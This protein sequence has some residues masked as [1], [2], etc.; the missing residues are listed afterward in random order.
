MSVLFCMPLIGTDWPVWT[1]KDRDWEEADCH[2]GGLGV[3]F[4]F[5]RFSCLM[6]STSSE[7]SSD[8]LWR[9]RREAPTIGSGYDSP[10]RQ[11]RK[12]SNQTVQTHQ[13][14]THSNVTTIWKSFTISTSPQLTLLVFNSREAG[15]WIIHSGPAQKQICD[16]HSH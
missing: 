2:D 11:Q 13:T 6:V 7:D 14:H 4:I 12:T 10:V 9:K 8:I 3:F 16:V 5:M 1:V 15:G